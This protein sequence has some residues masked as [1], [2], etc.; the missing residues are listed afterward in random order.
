MLIKLKSLALITDL[1]FVKENGEVLERENYLVVKTHS[2]PNFFWGNFLIFKNA[3]AQG[4]LNIW[5]NLFKKEFTDTKIYHQAFAWDEEVFGE[6]AQF[7]KAG[8]K[9]EK[10]VVL[11][12]KKNQIK[13]PVKNNSRVEIC[14]LK[15]ISDWNSVIEMQTATNPEYKSFYEKQAISYKKMTDK[16]LGIWFGAYLNGKIVASLGLFTDGHLGR[17]QIVSTHPEYQRQGICGTL[18]YKVSQYAFQKMN[19][20]KL[21]MVADEDYHAAKVYESVG[22]VPTEKMYGLCWYDKEKC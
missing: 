3:P 19:I 2:N 20:D 8:F 10:S 1:I 12:A 9:F 5:I 7:E 14:P 13:F 11:T 21:V 4:D 15:D 6:I 16:K 18:V 17:F 22:F